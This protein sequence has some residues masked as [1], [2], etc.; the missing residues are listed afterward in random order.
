MFSTFD[1]NKFPFSSSDTSSLISSPHFYLSFRHSFHASKTHAVVS[2]QFQLYA[3]LQQLSTCLSVCT[4]RSATDQG[5]WSNLVMPLLWR[6]LL[7]Y[8]V[9]GQKSHDWPI[10]LRSSGDRQFFTIA[11]ICTSII[12]RH[13]DPAGGVDTTDLSGASG[14][15]HFN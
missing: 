10:S 11:S 13:H 5:I 4:N 15:L 14:Y 6:K 8:R 9:R 12:G 3:V 2:C 7:T 1:E